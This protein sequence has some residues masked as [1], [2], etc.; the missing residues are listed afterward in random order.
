M[1]VRSRRALENGPGRAELA[2]CVQ[3]F[4]NDAPRM[5]W[6]R[7]GYDGRHGILDRK[8][9]SGLPNVRLVHDFPRYI[10]AMA[11]GY[12]VAGPWATRPRRVSA[13]RWMR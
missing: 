7:D 2:A 11:A 9:P 12:L 13:T 10:S 5:Q 4:L 8:R 6:L 3:E 1:I